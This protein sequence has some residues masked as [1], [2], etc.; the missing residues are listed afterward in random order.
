MNFFNTNNINKNIHYPDIYFTPEYGKACECSDNAEWELCQF[1]DLIYVYLKRPYV[2][3]E[4]TYYDLISPYG[5]AG[6]YFEKQE[7]FDEFIPLFREEAV[8]RNYLTEVNR[9]SP[10]INMSIKGS[11]D[12]IM[13]RTTM[14]I[15]LTKY[16]SFDDYLKHTY[17]D[18]RRSYNVAVRNNLIV[19]REPFNEKTKKSFINIYNSTMN[20]LQS[21]MYYYFNDKYFEEFC[22][23][24]HVFIMNVYLEDK[25]IA[26]CMIFC[27]KDKLHYHLGGSFLE[28]RN[29]RPNNLI[30]C[31]VIKYGI[32]NGFK[33]YH[34]GGGI[35]DGDSL[36]DFKC[37]IADTMHD[38]IIYK[39]VL[40]SEIYK[41]IE[42]MYPDIT[43]FPAHRA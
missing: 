7:T 23:N 25:Q 16:S 41:K 30:H 42:K 3:D 5:Y 40:N 19:K 17:K 14:G 10:Y 1:K 15:D 11:Y 21:T 2:F 20:H 4:K 24:P 43:Y 38:Y 39:N 28:Y 26:S 27:Y 32:E 22:D 31:S 8:K 12:T 13:S 9:Q 36:Y 29:M 18:N 35:K 33:M 37:K 34:L 6:Y